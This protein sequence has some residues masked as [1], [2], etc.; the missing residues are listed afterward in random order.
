MPKGIMD[1]ISLGPVHFTSEKFKNAALFLR[2]GLPIDTNPSRKRSFL[3]KAF[4][5]GEI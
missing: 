4:Q 2:L 1:N 5:T 3:K